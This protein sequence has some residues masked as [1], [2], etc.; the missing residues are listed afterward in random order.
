MLHYFPRF[1]FVSWGAGRIS[2]GRLLLSPELELGRRRRGTSYILL[3]LLCASRAT[4]CISAR[5]GPPD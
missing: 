4:I 5:A 1:P 3:V 2:S